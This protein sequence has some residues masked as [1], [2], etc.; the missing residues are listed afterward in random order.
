LAP[1]KWRMPASAVATTAIPIVII[2]RRDNRR[3][4]W[5][6]LPP[7]ARFATR[8]LLSYHRQTHDVN[9]YNMAARSG[10]AAKRVEKRRN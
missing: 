3:S 2:C 8:T 5:E 10:K 1:A 6:M 7:L 9:Q 4:A